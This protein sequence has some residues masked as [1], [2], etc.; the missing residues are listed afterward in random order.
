MDAEAFAVALRTLRKERNL[1]QMQLAKETGLSQRQISL[2]ESQKESPRPKAIERLR[3]AFRLNAEEWAA[4]LREA[5]DAID[6]HK[7]IDQPDT[8]GRRIRVMRMYFK[9]SQSAFAKDLGIS[10][11][12]I[13]AIEQDSAVPSYE[14]ICVLGRMGFN[15]HWI[16]YGESDNLPPRAVLDHVAGSH[17]MQKIH[18]LLETLPTDKLTAVRKAMELLLRS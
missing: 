10:Q 14:V 1:T 8:I 15:L 3:E 13:S 12:A 17:E 18:K 16:L 6:Q 9:Q 4:A 11:S 7:G 2:W 5:R